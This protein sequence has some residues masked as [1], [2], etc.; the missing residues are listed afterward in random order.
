MIGKRMCQILH[1]STKKIDLPAH[2]WKCKFVHCQQ[3]Q[4][5]DSP[6]VALN[7]SESRI[8]RNVST[9][10][11]LVCTN[12]VTSCE[13]EQIC[14]IKSFLRTTITE[15]R[16]SGPTLL[17]IHSTFQLTWIMLLTG[18]HE[19]TQ[20]S[21]NYYDVCMQMCIFYINLCMYLFCF[22]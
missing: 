17:H 20:K 2:L 9:L 3:N 12:P 15:D 19:S 8:F 5:P 13:A 11:E 7:Q 14:W 6:I 4:S 21:Y 18:L 1:Y 10:L 22:W 16:F